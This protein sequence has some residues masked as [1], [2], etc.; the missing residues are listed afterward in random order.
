MV[1][2]GARADYLLRVGDIGLFGVFYALSLA[3][4]WIG[5]KYPAKKP[6]KGNVV[7]GLRNVAKVP[8]TPEKRH[9]TWDCVSD[10]TDTDLLFDG[11]SLS[12]DKIK[13]TSDHT[14]FKT[15]YN[16]LINQPHFHASHIPSTMFRITCT[17]TQ[18]ITVSFGSKHLSS[19]CA[20]VELL[21]GLVDI[22]YP[23][24]WSYK[25]IGEDVAGMR[26]AIAGAAG[27]REHSVGLSR[28]SRGGRY[29]SLNL[30][31]V[32]DSEAERDAIGNALNCSSAVRLEL[33]SQP[34]QLISRF[35][36]QLQHPVAVCEAS[37]CQR[38][39]CPICTRSV[40]TVALSAWSA[41]KAWSQAS[42]ST[43]RRLSWARD[44]GDCQVYSN[45][46]LMSEFAL[47]VVVKTSSM[48]DSSISS[49]FC[50]PAIV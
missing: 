33:E 35:K 38:S 30:E 4:F 44:R 27:G 2:L 18:G 39:M 25:V 40:R 5:D 9:S 43:F 6:P 13:F 36:R 1:S 37:P 45:C 26:A 49:D 32:V 28:V 12:L 50:Y 31:V 11:I 8:P 15:R 17:N 24:S 7:N 41:D 42:V 3:V 19:S 48:F 21:M 10:F 23:T 16:R 22:E 34:S 14:T 20:G 47:Q 46:C 29:V